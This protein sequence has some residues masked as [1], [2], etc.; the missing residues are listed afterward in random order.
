MATRSVYATGEESLQLYPH[1]GDGQNAGADRPHT[2]N[3]SRWAEAPSGDLQGNQMF[4]H[5]QS[6]SLSSHSRPSLQPSVASFGESMAQLSLEQ[7]PSLLSNPFALDTSPGAHAPSQPP[8][9]LLSPTSIGEPRHRDDPVKAEPLLHDHADAPAA[10]SRQGHR[11]TVFAA[12]V[13]AVTSKKEGSSRHEHRHMWGADETAALVTGCTKYGVGNWKAILNDPEL[14]PRFNQDRHPG[15]LKDRFRTK[16]P[17]AYHELYP[18]AKTHV[19][20]QGLRKGS[21]DGTKG[22][23]EKGKS[24][25]RRCFTPAEDAVLKQGYET[26]GSSWTSIARDPIF[27]GRRKP[28][29]LRDRFR[30]AFPELYAQAGYKPRIKG[31]KGKERRL[32]HGASHAPHSHHDHAV[33]LPTEKDTSRA[34]LDALV[35]GKSEPLQNVPMF[36]PTSQVS[37]AT[38][39]IFTPTGESSSGANSD[40]DVT[41]SQSAAAA[42]TTSVSADWLSKWTTAPQGQSGTAEMTR[43]SSY[44]ST[45]AA[46]RASFSAGSSAPP[47]PSLLTQLS[48]PPGKGSLSHIWHDTFLR[49]SPVNSASSDTGSHD[50]PGPSTGSRHGKS[51][52]E[53]DERSKMAQWHLR[54]AQLIHESLRAEEKLRQQRQ[55]TSHRSSIAS[56]A[57]AMSSLGGKGGALRRTQSSKRAKAKVG[58]VHAAPAP[59]ALDHTHADQPDLLRDGDVQTLGLYE[60]QGQSQSL[61]PSLAPPADFDPNNLEASIDED[62]LKQINDLLESHAAQ[63]MQARS[64][65]LQQSTENLTVPL[66]AL[67]TDYFASPH[68]IL[69][70]PASTSG[71]SIYSD[72]LG[73]SGTQSPPSGASY[74]GL[75]E[76]MAQ[77][78]DPRRPTGDPGFLSPGDQPEQGWD[79]FVR[80]LSHSSHD[81]LTSSSLTSDSGASQYSHHSQRSAGLELANGLD[82]L[83]VLGGND[84][85]STEDRRAFMTSNLAAMQLAALRG[86]IADFELFREDQ[87]RSESSVFSD[88]NSALTEGSASG[89][90]QESL[91]GEYDEASAG[92]LSRPDSSASHH[93]DYSDDDSDGASEEMEDDL[94]PRTATIQPA[95]SPTLAKFSQHDSAADE[96]AYTKPPAASTYPA[97]DL[98]LAN[99]LPANSEGTRAV[100]RPRSSDT[101]REAFDTASPLD[102]LQYLQPSPSPSLLRASHGPGIAE[103][104]ATPLEPVAESSLSPEMAASSRPHSSLS[105]L[106]RVGD[107]APPFLYSATELGP[108]A[109]GPALGTPT[110]ESLGTHPRSGSYPSSGHEEGDQYESRGDA[111]DEYDQEGYSFDDIDLSALLRGQAPIGPLDIGDETAEPYAEGLSAREWDLGLDSPSEWPLHAMMSGR[112]DSPDQLDSA[113]F[114]S[115]SEDFLTRPAGEGTQDTAAGLR[116]DASGQ[117]SIQDSGDAVAVAGDRSQ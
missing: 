5:V 21:S 97:D 79:S 52:S 44:S 58:T 6:R 43:S 101:L 95:R 39:S 34:D 26:Y 37:E 15:D 23:F 69:P 19:A 33:P 110:E 55:R 104:G 8:L 24:K 87:A 50:L 93:A 38:S 3:G 32:S 72:P 40:F 83:A 53:H 114:D 17:D 76:S 109:D 99:S 111:E 77:I 90:D 70:G 65:D 84:H 94:L 117:S 9:P 86:D 18:N 42:S 80:A 20:P 22:Q 108:A 4:G 29:D 14:R 10:S 56:T 102:L 68:G 88:S 66:N 11:A 91:N 85:D 115:P 16:F 2:V 60:A 105:S 25:E 30:N 49:K 92:S 106:S 41:S 59:L 116:K 51:T 78:G 100:R 67:Q 7:R 112:R 81:L 74:R 27:E 47:R 62:Q 71:G 35:L 28:T 54:Q 63:T 48:L 73:P 12:T 1:H 36:S 89:T 45:G 61:P 113:G 96:P 82:R 103:R 46:S 57:G 64:N 13:P 31:G 75:L 98:S 107:D